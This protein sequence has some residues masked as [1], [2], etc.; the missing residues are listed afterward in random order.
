[1]PQTLRA[2]NPMPQMPTGWKKTICPRR[3]SG[4]RGPPVGKKPFAHEGGQGLGPHR[5]EKSR[6]VTK[7]V[8]PRGKKPFAHEGGQGLGPPRVEKKTICPRRGS[9]FRAPPG[10][11]NHL[12]TKGPGGKKTVWSR[13][14]SGFRA[15][16]WGKK[17]FGHEGGQGLGPSRGE[18]NRLVTKGVRV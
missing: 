5:G 4:F 18:K 7:G 2:L 16:P 6:L 12:P 11:K 10:G 14:G 13:R 3:G 15:P 8:P 1:M 17:P 9:G